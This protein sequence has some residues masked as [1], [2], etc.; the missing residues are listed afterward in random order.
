[1][2]EGG[3]VLRRIR[4]VGGTEFVFMKRL[5][6]L[7]VGDL[8][9]PSFEI[10]VG[11]MAYGFPGEGVLGLN[12]LRQSGALINLRQLELHRASGA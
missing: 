5:D 8:E 9:A 4:G 11:A 3:D 10:E 6:H 7:S 2:P 1:M 12:F